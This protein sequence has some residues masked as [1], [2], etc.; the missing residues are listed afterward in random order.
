MKR[1]IIGLGIVILLCSGFSFKAQARYSRWEGWCGCNQN[2]ETAEWD[3]VIKPEVLGDKL[4]I[5]VN[6]AFIAGPRCDEYITIT[7]DMDNWKG[8]TYGLRWSAL[9]YYYADIPLSKLAK[10]KRIRMNYVIMRDAKPARWALF[11]EDN[12]EEWTGPGDRK[13]SAVIDF[14]IKNKRVEPFE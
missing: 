4:H 11:S 7:G 12:D 5:I 6:P 13:G 9:G 8:D 10:N 2:L 1:I 14:V 3:W